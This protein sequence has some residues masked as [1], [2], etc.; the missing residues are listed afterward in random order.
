VSGHGQRGQAT[1]ELV[2]LLPLLAAV[3]L[4]AYT[5][6]AAH[7]AAEQA[8]SAAEAGAVALLQ[9]REPAAA[10]REALGAAAGRARITVRAPR[11]SVDVRP[12]VPLL[13]TRLTARATAHAGGEPAR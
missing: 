11:V 1:V 5:A 3:S 7:R 4:A 10:A 13:A 12:D 8:G 6:L 2:G 9:D